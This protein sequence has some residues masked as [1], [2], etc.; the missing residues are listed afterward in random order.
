MPLT[1][2]QFEILE[3]IERY[4]AQNSYPPT[5]REIQQALNISSTSVVDYN[6]NTLERQGF[7]RRNRH[8]SRGIELVY[9]RVTDDTSKIVRI[10]L[11]GH[12]AAGRPIPVLE[13]AELSTVTEHIEISADLVGAPEGLFALRVRGISMLDALINDGDIVVLRRQ[14]SAENGE[15]VAVWLRR[16]QE[17]TLKRFYHEGSR[18]RLQP[19]NAFLQPI[20][21]TPDNVEIQGKVVLVLRTLANTAQ[22]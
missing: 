10:P 7:I 13:T 17:T 8:I 11:L 9:R 19:A 6:L 20:Y 21:T 12:I 18:I 15:T 1:E 14:S 22:H 4:I 5:I 3:F 16:E 2:K